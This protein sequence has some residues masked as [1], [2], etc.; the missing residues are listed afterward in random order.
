MGSQ[1]SNVSSCERL[2]LWSDSVEAQTGF[3]IHSTHMLTDT[4]WIYW[5]YIVMIHFAV[6]QMN[7]AGLKDW[8]EYIV[9]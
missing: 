2:R 7:N 9:E 6:L 4:G 1:A 3:N 8:E 5:H